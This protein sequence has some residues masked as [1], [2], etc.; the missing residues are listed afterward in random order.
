MARVLPNWSD[1]TGRGRMSNNPMTLPSSSKASEETPVTKLARWPAPIG[2]ETET[3]PW[4]WLGRSREPGDESSTR[5]ADAT[6]AVVLW[7]Y[8]CRASCYETTRR[9][10]LFLGTATEA[11]AAEAAAAVAA[12]AGREGGGSITEDR[13][14]SGLGRS[15]AIRRR[16]RR[17]LLPHLALSRGADGRLDALR[18]RDRMASRAPCHRR[19]VFTAKVTR[20]GGLP[21]MPHRAYSRS[22]A[23]AR[24]LTIYWECY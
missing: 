24:P 18:R 17:R 19:P 9:P 23:H 2:W 15:I 21:M 20:P 6:A 14:T 5:A 22:E 12:A 13:C 8:R 16:G 11:A 3:R 7:Q 4:P 1:A 10:G